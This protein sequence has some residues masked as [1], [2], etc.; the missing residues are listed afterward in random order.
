MKDPRAHVNRLLQQDWNSDPTPF[1]SRQRA[2]A[3]C[4]H[5]LLRALLRDIST[6]EYWLLRLPFHVRQV[7]HAARDLHGSGHH[8]HCDL[9]QHDKIFTCTCGLE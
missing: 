8:E 6:E 4:S 5:Q 2:M 9:R 1:T 7:L 3:A